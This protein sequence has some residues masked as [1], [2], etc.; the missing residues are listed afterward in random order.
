MNADVVLMTKGKAGMPKPNCWIADLGAIA[1]MTN[2]LEGMIDVKNST[3]L[4][5]VGNC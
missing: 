3:I 4:V 1:N 5:K 2:S